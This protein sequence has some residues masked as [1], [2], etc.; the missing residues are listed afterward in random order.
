M[1]C[2]VASGGESR[3]SLMAGASRGQLAVW[4]HHRRR[5]WSSFTYDLRLLLKKNI[6]RERSPR[7]KECKD[8]NTL[9]FSNNRRPHFN[10]QKKDS[11]FQAFNSVLPSH[12]HPRTIT[13]IYLN[14][15]RQRP[16]NPL[17]VNKNKKQRCPRE[18]S[19]WARWIHPTC[20]RKRKS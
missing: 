16:S 19:K 18:L 9:F 3:F 11:S 17:H 7:I 20:F 12:C 6:N 4:M 10:L 13:A 5:D 1:S 15:R 8:C 14:R 2:E